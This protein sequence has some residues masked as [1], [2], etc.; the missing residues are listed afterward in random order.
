MSETKAR[1][2]VDLCST[3]PKR[4][5][6]GRLVMNAVVAGA[7]RPVVFMHGLGWD[8]T[9]WGPQVE[10]LRTRYRV[11][12]ADTRGHG[13]T[14]KPEGPY[15]IDQ[16]TID[17]ISLIRTLGAYP[18]LFVGF[19]LGGMIAQQIAT[20]AP[21]LVGGLVLVSTSC[22]SPDVGRDHMEKRL[23]AMTA[24]GPVAA[25]KLAAESIFSESWRRAHPQRLEA[26][27]NWRAAQDQPALREVMRAV[28]NFD[29]TKGLPGISVPTLVL[30]ALGDTLMRPEAQ[31]LIL[32]YVPHATQANVSGSG[33]MVSIEK[34]TEFD[35]ILDDFLSKHWAPS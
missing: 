33:H 35:S 7:G 18:A 20:I 30:T 17:W 3:P 23:A 16:F 22:R 6:T 4:I 2:I 27:V 10:R 11:I 12:A 21:E 32:N 29:V 25:A 24:D 8:N 9:L 5:D 26:F 28:M 13:E 19:S 14:D 1:S 15:S 31:S 34:P